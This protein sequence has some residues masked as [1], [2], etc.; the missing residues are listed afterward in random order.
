MKKKL[1]II[2]AVVVLATACYL[3]KEGS[4]LVQNLQVGKAEN[5]I[6]IDAGH[7]GMDPGKIGINGEEEKTINLS[8]ALKLKTLLEGQDIKVILT[9]TGDDGLYSEAS[10]NRKVED[11]RK[12]CEIITKNM[13]IFTIS[14][15]QNSYTQE[16]IK[17]SQVFYYG[18]SVEG[19]KLAEIIQESMVERL[20]PKNHRMAK[21]NESYYLLR[22]TPTPT[23]IVECGFLSNVGEAKLL[24][25]E[26]YQEK[27]AQAVHI[28]I[29]KYLKK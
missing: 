21:A 26:E 28:G 12:R 20:D 14:I 18:Q 29:M 9:R 17:G 15:H 24:T 19:K 25:T 4:V 16:S 10:K 7:G 23:V 22:R 13:P 8:I 2:M 1:E 5:C 27:V 11:M 3:A 6:V